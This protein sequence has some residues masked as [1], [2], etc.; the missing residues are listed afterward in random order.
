MSKRFRIT[1]IKFTPIGFLVTFTASK[2]HSIDMLCKETNKGWQNLHRIS[3][4]VAGRQFTNL[5]TFI[6]DC[7]GGYCIADIRTNKKG[8]LY[9]EELRPVTDEDPQFI[10]TTEDLFDD[11]EE[12]WADVWDDG[13]GWMVFTKPDGSFIMKE[14]DS[15]G[16]FI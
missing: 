13:D 6:S 11:D 4:A 7:L 14:Y 1:S 8:Q 15:A 10:D 9:F 16:M 3:R 12:E 5:E 2:T